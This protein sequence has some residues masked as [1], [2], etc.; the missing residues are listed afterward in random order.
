MGVF[1]EALDAKAV[2]RVAARTAGD[3]VTAAELK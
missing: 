2:G 1:L 3:R